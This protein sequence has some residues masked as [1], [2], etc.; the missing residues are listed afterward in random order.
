MGSFANELIALDKTKPF[1]FKNVV[2][3][4]P[5]WHEFITHKEYT[6]QNKPH[7]F[8]QD[9]PMLSIV[10]GDPYDEECHLSKM[11]SLRPFVSDLKKVFSNN[12]MADAAFVISESNFGTSGLGRHPDPGKQIHLNCVGI[13]EWTVWKPNN[14]VLYNKYILEPGDV[15]YLPIWWEHSVVSL[16]EKRAGIAYTAD[17]E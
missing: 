12:L 1:L 10:F 4:V 6:K 11:K 2:N 9:A 13:S 5:N 16:T 14:G 17:K 7:L 3:P 15:I 8:R